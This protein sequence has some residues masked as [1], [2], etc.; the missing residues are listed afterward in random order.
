MWLARL[1]RLVHVPAVSR[2]SR[3]FVGAAGA[4]WPRLP[5][6]SSGSATSAGW[7]RARQGQLVGLHMG[8]GMTVAM[9]ATY[10]T[11]DIAATYGVGATSTLLLGFAAWGVGGRRCW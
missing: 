7:L 1:G 6:A 4:V 5:G 3:K 2:V 9:A 11:F 8:V 10:A